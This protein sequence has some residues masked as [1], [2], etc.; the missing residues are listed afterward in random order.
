MSRPA[1]MAARSARSPARRLG[2]RD[3]ALKIASRAACLT[4]L[5]AN[6]RQKFLR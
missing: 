4:G 5:R 2:R 1:S 6:A 3:R